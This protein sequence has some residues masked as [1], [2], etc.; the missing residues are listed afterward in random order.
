[1]EQLV[2]EKRGDEILARRMQED[3]PGLVFAHGLYTTIAILMAGF[4]FVFC[5]QLLLFLFL[6]LAIDS[7]LTSQQSKIQAWPLTVT[8]FS[9]P[10]F[11][12]GLANAM[13]IAQ[14]FVVETWE[15]NPILKTIFAK[16]QVIV[17]WYT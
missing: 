17:D 12:F 13:T 3:F 2:L 15:G 7:G 8:I 11:C 4:M 9:I 14:T 16:D 1:M 10:V 6:G 5:I